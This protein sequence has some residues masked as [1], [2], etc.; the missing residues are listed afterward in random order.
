MER[1]FSLLVHCKVYCREDH[2]FNHFPPRA[3]N[4]EYQW[5]TI[6]T[7]PSCV[8]DRPGGRGQDVCHD[9]AWACCQR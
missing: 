6:A 8:Y 7:G 3:V 4:R 9:G 2:L 5:V 1:P